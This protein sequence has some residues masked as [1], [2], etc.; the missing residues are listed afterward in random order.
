[1][2]G[3][4]SIGAYVPIYRLS[5]DEI[6]RMWGGRSMGGEKAVAG[7]DEDSVTMAVASALDTMKD[8]KEKMDGLYF[9]TTTAPYKEKQ[10]AAII[11]SAIDLEKTCY[12]GDFT[13]SLRAGS[14]ALKSAIDA[15]KCGSA[16]NIM[17]LASDCRIGAAQS[18]FEQILGDGAAS[19]V[20]GSQNV[21]AEVEGNY[22]I[23]NEFVDV[24]RTDEDVFE[25]G[26]E[27]RFID[28][29]GYRPVMNGVISGLMDKYNLT[30]KDFSKVVFYA[31][32]ARSHNNMAKSLGFEKDQ[33]Q[34]PL[35]MRIGNTGTA[36]AFIM[37]AD[38]MNN[39]VPG[40]RILFI[41]YGDGADAFIFRVTK[42]IEEAQ[43]AQTVRGQLEAKVPINYARYAIWRGLVR[44]EASKLAERPPVSVQCLSREKRNV[45]ALY[46]VKCISCGTPQYPASRVCVMCHAKDNFEEYKFSLRKGKLFTFSVDRLE[47]TLNPPGVNGVVD[48]DGG[49]RLVCDLTDCD[50]EKIEAGAAVEMTFRKLYQSKGIN[51]YFWK[52][53]PV[54]EDQ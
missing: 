8:N 29:G 38:A 22:S 41:T 20:I 3:I 7:C 2:V 31:S 14:L 23:F 25:R 26:S 30:P 36:A 24:W 53:K 17:V 45:L 44:E 46:G 50:P 40:D 21:I 28:I 11:A 1:M 39:A 19:L 18:T 43:P 48:F 9:A 33:I 37:L 12:T 51:S 10:A 52:A 27:E 16:G 42:D 5:G 34:D 54:A 32:D 6:A 13:N 49:G 47:Q 15:V 4:T 35:F